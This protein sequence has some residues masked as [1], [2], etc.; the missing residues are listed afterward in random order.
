MTTAAGKATTSTIK[1]GQDVRLTGANEAAFQMLCFHGGGGVGGAPDMM[2]GFAANMVK[3]MSVR[4]AMP[5]YR[6]LN[7]SPQA[8]LEDMLKDAADALHWSKDNLQREGLWLLGA[9]F[10]GLLALDAALENPEGIAGLILL[11][12]VTDT[13][14]GGFANRVVD[15][16][17]HAAL[18]PL[19]RYKSHPALTKLRCLIVHGVEDD[20]VPVQASRDFAA[21][22]PE[23]QCELVELP[24]ATHGFFNRSPRDA[25]TATLVKRFV[26][27]SKPVGKAKKRK[28]PADVRL[29][30]C[31]GAQKAGTSWLYD[32]ITKSP[33]AHRGLTKERH[34]FDVLWLNEDRAFLDPK[35]E[36]LKSLAEDVVTGFDP[37]NEKALRK[38][39]WLTEQLAPFAADK[40]DHGAYINTMTKHLRA[41]V[42]S[43][44]KVVCDFTPSY[45]GLSGEH[46]SEISAMGDVRFIY[47]LRDPVARMWSQ[48]RMMMAASGSHDLAERCAVHA[49][50]MCRSGKMSQIFR[51]DYIRTLDALDQGASK[52][53]VV[54][55]ERLFEQKT[56][57]RLAAFSGITPVEIDSR[58]KVNEGQPIPLPADLEQRM[59]EALL[60]QYEAVMA[61][62]GNEVP[63]QWHERYNRY[64]G[65]VLE[66]RGRPAPQVVQDTSKMFKKI[67]QKIA[68]KTSGTQVAFLHIPKT[69]GQSIVKELRRV[70]G[71]KSHSPV[72]THTQAARDAQMPAGYRVYAGHIDWVDLE[73]LD[74][75]R[76]SFS[77]LRNP[78]ERIASF[79]FYLKR[80]AEKL[81]PEQLALKENTGKR[82]ILSLSAED[83]FFGG[84]RP[85]Q[86]FV[87]DHYDNFY[88]TYFAT[89]RIRGWR[90]INELSDEDLLKQALAGAEAVSGLYG[91]GELARLETD[92]SNVLGAKVDLQKTRVNTG[93]APKSGKRWDDLM[94]LFES[95]EN[96]LKLEA[97]AKRDEEFMRRIGLESELS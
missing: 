34:Y 94:A 11:N 82:N 88:T 49:H 13:G 80:E 41:P 83:Y 21:L 66:W 63:V 61:R 4:M 58:K 26:G 75:D 30:C 59:L 20:V 42:N 32:Q 33:E 76:F 15:P 89:R 56:F 3:T 8:T 10:G 81:T 68:P 52:Y 77:V 9:S 28:L 70:C 53:D 1:D 25:E 62:F 92:L 78:R 5:Q 44:E 55:Y 46:F 60:P 50:D 12:P 57:D 67:R 7:T 93:P 54:F 90:E 24:N 19:E 17:Q 69:A 72:R 40:G 35:V 43:S 74:D 18:S 87:H 37:N 86:V 39:S 29:I 6:V 71:D 14:A 51:A 73:T 48:I 79:Y 23:G 84:D 91:M 65:P 31:I 16:S 95:P 36:G 38:I 47:I 85:W 45:C 96:R 64:D 2:D 27:P 97:F 22:W